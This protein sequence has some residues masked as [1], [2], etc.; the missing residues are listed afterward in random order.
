MNEQKAMTQKTYQTSHGTIVYWIGEPTAEIAK[1]QQQSVQAKRSL[2]FLP[3]LTADH[4]LFDKQIEVFSLTCQVLTWSV[5]AIFSGFLPYGS[6]RMAPGNP[7]P[8]RN[9]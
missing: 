7:G 5:P 2:I 9:P 3:G 8:G 4:R 1:S 6:G